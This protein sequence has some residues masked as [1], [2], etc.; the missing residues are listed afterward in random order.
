MPVTPGSQKL[1]SAAQVSMK[2]NEEELNVHDLI[3]HMALLSMTVT[4]NHIH[5]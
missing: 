3:P 2:Q 4:L 5:I 1:H